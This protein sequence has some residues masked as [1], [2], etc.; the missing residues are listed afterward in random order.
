[1]I[2]KVIEDTVMTVNTVLEVQAF[3]LDIYGQVE[4]AQTE[5]LDSLQKEFPTCIRYG[6]RFRSKRVL[7][8]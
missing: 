5:W 8:F 3:S 1:M 7:M 2:E 6:D 4:E